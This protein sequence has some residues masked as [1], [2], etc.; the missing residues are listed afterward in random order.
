MTGKPD[1]M[2]P[3]WL[4]L[5]NLLRNSRSVNVKITLHLYC[6]EM[7]EAAR[8]IICEMMTMNVLVTKFCL[9]TLPFR[10]EIFRRSVLNEQNNIK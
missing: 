9:T 4:K 5:C 10:E 1:V 6:R 3:A 7:W 8:L 2:F